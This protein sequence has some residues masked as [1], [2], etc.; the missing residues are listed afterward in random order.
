MGWWDRIGKVGR[1]I[2]ALLGILVTILAVFASASRQQTNAVSESVQS[3]DGNVQG[4]GEPLARIEEAL[5]GEDGV[6]HEL[7]VIQVELDRQTGDLGEQ[8]T[9]LGDIRDQI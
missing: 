7:D 9:V 5:V 6:V 3:V 8:L 2:G 1:G 4:N